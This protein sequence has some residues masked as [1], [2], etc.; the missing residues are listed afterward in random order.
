MAEHGGVLPSPGHIEERPETVF[1]GSGP[2]LGRDGRGLCWLPRNI[3]ECCLENS[4]QQCSLT[5]C[6]TPPN[7]MEMRLLTSLAF[8]L[9]KGASRPW[10]RAAAELKEG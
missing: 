8:A 1:W 7:E 4:E 5:L 9:G 2:C 3:A 6:L 10:H